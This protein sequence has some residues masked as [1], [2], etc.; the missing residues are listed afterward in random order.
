MQLAGLIEQ[1]QGQG[2]HLLRVRP[3]PVKPFRP[4]A[5]CAH[6]VHAM[7]DGLGEVLEAHGTQ[8]PGH[9]LRVVGHPVQLRPHRRKLEQ[10][11]GGLRPVPW[12]PHAPRV[13]EQRP[14][15][16]PD[17]GHMRMAGHYDVRPRSF[18]DLPEPRFGGAREQPLLLLP[19][20]G[21]DD[22]QGAPA[23]VQAQLLRKG[24][25]PFPFPLPQ[26]GRRHL[27]LA[28][29]RSPS[30]LG[31]QDRAVH[32]AQHAEALRCVQG[33]DRLPRPREPYRVP[34]V[35]E[36]GRSPL[37]RVL[38]HRP[39]RGRVAMHIGEQGQDNRGA[40]PRSVPLQ[41]LQHSGEETLLD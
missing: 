6:G 5:Q 14:P 32:V 28:V 13:D 11:I 2:A 10:G 25:Q 33:P 8:L 30:P 19:R 18:H 15:A 39:Q 37:P 26:E 34:R 24:R 27:Q 1:E 22:Q 17:H 3:V 23:H 29:A 40:L 38:Q 20:R 7:D 12:P 31:A 41:S 21:M 35:Q 4:G 36:G 9:A 16:G